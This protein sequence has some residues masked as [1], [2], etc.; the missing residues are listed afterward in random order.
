MKDHLAVVDS[1]ARDVIKQRQEQM[2]RGEVYK[3]LLSR[4]MVAKNAEG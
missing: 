2:A 3:D 4:C 1:F